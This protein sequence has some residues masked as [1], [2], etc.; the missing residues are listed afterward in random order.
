M[1]AY[2]YYNNRYLLV[3]IVVNLI[4]LGIIHIFLFV[5]MP[6]IF[7]LLITDKN[8]SLRHN[9]PVCFSILSLVVNRIYLPLKIFRRLS[10]KEREIMTPVTI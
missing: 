9:H 3:Q 8:F 5:R 7:I 6:H 4:R 2:Q 1:V 10:W